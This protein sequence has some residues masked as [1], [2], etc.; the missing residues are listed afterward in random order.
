MRRDARAAR[1][2]QLMHVGERGLDDEPSR[3]EALIIVDVQND[4]CPGGALAVAGGDEVVAPLNELAR[5]SGLVVATRDWHARDHSSFRDHGG[6][7][8]VHCVAASAGAALHPDLDRCAIDIVL[9]KGRAPD[10][11]GYSA[12]EKTGL[13]ALLR[14][15]GITRLHIGGLALDY[16]VRHTALDARRLG[17]EVVLHLAATRAV[18][19][20]AGDAERTRA[21]LAAA[22]VEIEA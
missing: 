20:R 21:Q 10:L 16:C 15:R 8:P 7:W 17:F 6:P 22:G 3:R 12:F 4:F 19:A 14:E 18:E 13:A 9:D 5:N 11:A 1:L 2:W